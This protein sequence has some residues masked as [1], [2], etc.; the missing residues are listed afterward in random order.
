MFNSRKFLSTLRNDLHTLSN[1]QVQ[2]SYLRFFKEPVKFYGISSAAVQKI[3]K[4]K[5]KEIKN[6][7]K[8]EIF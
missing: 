6:L 4:E 3:A 2:K 5:W 1:P 7:S 8:K